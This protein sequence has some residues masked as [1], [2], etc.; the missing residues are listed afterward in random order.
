MGTL[1]STAERVESAPISAA[2]NGV[3][4]ARETDHGATPSIHPL[5]DC[6]PI[7]GL[8]TEAQRGHLRKLD[9]L[10]RSI[11][12]GR[13]G[14][15]LFWGPALDDKGN[16]NPKMPAPWRKGWD[17]PNVIGTG[18]NTLYATRDT[19]D[20][21]ALIGSPEAIEHG[22]Q[23]V[24]LLL[25]ALVD[26]AVI[27]DFDRVLEE[28]GTPNKWGKWVL[29]HFG[30][31]Y[32]E[33]SPSGRGLRVVVRGVIDWISPASV[34]LEDVPKGSTE[35]APS[36]EVYIQSCGVYMDS[37][38]GSK[39]VR[40][41]GAVVRECSGEPREAQAGLD[42]LDKKLLERKGVRPVLKPPRAKGSG[43]GSGGPGGNPVD[44]PTAPWEELRALEGWEARGTGYLWTK[45][46]RIAD[47]NAD[48]KTAALLEGDFSPW[49]GDRS[50]V[51]YFACREAI[52]HGAGDF[53]TV[54]EFWKK[55]KAYRHGG[56]PD[57]RPGYVQSTI[58][59]ALDLILERWDAWREA[60]QAE[61]SNNATTKEVEASVTSAG[62][63]V[64]KD[65]VGTLRLVEVREIDG[66]L[67]RDIM[68]LES[69][70][71][72]DTLRAAVARTGKSVT[73]DK[74]EEVVSSLRYAHRGAKEQG[75]YLRTYGH[76]D[77]AVFI[78][79]R[80][81][82]T[83]K[84]TAKG[85]DVIDDG[86]DAP[87]FMDKGGDLDDPEFDGDAADAFDHLLEQ[88]QQ[89]NMSERDA[90]MLIAAM[91]TWTLSD[92]LL[93]IVELVGPAYA[94]KSS[95]A[96]TMTS[97]LDSS[98]K[99]TKVKCEER[100]I[101]AAAQ[102][103]RVLS[104]ENEGRISPDVS[105]LLCTVATG[106]VTQ[107]SKF[108]TQDEVLSLDIQRGIV[109]SA[110]APV[111]T[112]AD[113]QS[114]VI[115]VQLG[116]LPKMDEETEV[117]PRIRRG[118][119]RNRGALLTLLSGSMKVWGQAPKGN[120]RMGA[121]GRM[122]GAMLMAAGR[123]PQAFRGMLAAAGAEMGLQAIE[124]D[125]WKSTLVRTLLKVTD[126]PTHEGQPTLTQA[127]K[128]LVSFTYTGEG[129]RL[130]AGVQAS[131]KTLLE[132]IRK[133][134]GQYSETWLPKTPT[135]L[136]NTIAGDLPQLEAVGITAERRGENTERPVWVFDFDVATLVQMD[137][138]DL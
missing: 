25:K 70:A 57:N 79:L 81:G 30:G 112:A 33:V 111:C 128:K 132:A 53:Q 16:I 74:L 12:R 94:G 4:M 64:F 36:V 17:A 45:M 85:W 19:E 118:A 51:D 46:Q 71:A 80:R 62:L 131:A 107:Q 129:G 123:D 136:S 95:L 86:P 98:E 38:F 83:A 28:N 60:D 138:H 63:S 42:V 24:G 88:F 96:F 21:L 78:R 13:K 113:L 65:K 103:S 32:V 114:R 43:G 93:P 15:W 73:R 34:A 68:H 69:T 99:V 104:L 108:Y 102:V 121:Y 27:L 9:K 6:P 10:T 52:K 44:D 125:R 89:W 135:A 105:N 39:F 100:D 110:L 26:D 130:R 134:A 97:M 59:N 137:F 67:V 116:R 40:M 11:E 82:Y 2:S 3:A 29:E 20:A 18:W 127:R 77:D 7:P 122:G 55:S 124:G 56:K 23:G 133:Q 119:A 117:Q 92:A 126:S 109:I 90:T 87:L 76:V 14:G 1:N 41:T 50:A 54:R 35:K 48:S 106:A 91:L 61:R 8:L 22:V 49:G 5:T 115:R 66:R 72:K 47:R 120:T 101:V 31:A 84:V 58:I 37:D 75:L